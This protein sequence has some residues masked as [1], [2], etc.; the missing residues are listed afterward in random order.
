MIALR[1]SPENEGFLKDLIP[2]LTPMLDILFILLVFFMLTIGQVFEGMDLTLPKSTAQKIQQTQID[3]MIVLSLGDHENSYAI[4]NRKFVTIEG[5]KSD[6]L[7]TVQDNPDE[8]II[9]AGDRTVSLERLL[10]ILTFLN[11]NGI[12]TANILMQSGDK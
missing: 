5:F 2:D 10:N 8:K 9:L 7:K 3:N 11:D 6:I 4:N 12:Q 1:Q